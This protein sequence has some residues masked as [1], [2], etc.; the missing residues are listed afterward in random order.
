MVGEKRPLPGRSQGSRV[1][2]DRFHSAGRQIQL[3]GRGDPSWVTPFS[4]S[5]LIRGST[6]SVSKSVIPPK[7]DRGR[8]I[9][10]RSA[11]AVHLTSIN[12]LLVGTV[13]RRSGNCFGRRE[14]GPVT[15]IQFAVEK[16]RIP[17]CFA[18]RDISTKP[19]ARILWSGTDFQFAPALRAS[20]TPMTSVTLG[21]S[22]RFRRRWRNVRA[23]FH[24][25]SHRLRRPDRD[26]TGG[27]S[28]SVTHG[29]HVGPGNYCS[30]YHQT[31]F[32]A[33]HKVVVWRGRQG[34]DRTNPGTE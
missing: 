3:D 13:R 32:K 4:L 34:R 24:E 11:V 22:R 25:C 14:Y 31:G 33:V 6:H 29:V 19:P 15:P 21:N 10:S 9:A 27:S 7:P 8:G 1:S 16:V 5:G 23:G 18:S 20:G 30:G 12:A 17:W 28:T 26:Q 2:A